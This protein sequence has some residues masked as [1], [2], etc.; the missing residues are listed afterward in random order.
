MFT[1]NLCAIE[2]FFNVDGRFNWNQ[3]SFFLMI[4]DTASKN[5]HI[6]IISYSLELNRQL[7]ALNARS[8]ICMIREDTQTD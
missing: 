6:D 7:K 8:M 5:V 1:Y 4:V 2:L 3:T